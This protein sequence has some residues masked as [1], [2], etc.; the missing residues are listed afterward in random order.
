MFGRVLHYITRK[1]AKSLIMLLILV[2]V[3]IMF[4]T[5]I[6]V[7]KSAKISLDNASEKAGS[8]FIIRN[9][10]QF[11]IG[12]TGGGNVPEKVIDDIASLDTVIKSSRRMISSA[13]MLNATLLEKPELYGADGF[14]LPEGMQN[15]LYIYGTD[16]SAADR[17]FAVETLRISE[18]RHINNESTNAVL[19]HEGF[20]THNGFK[21]GDT[22]TFSPYQGNNNIS[23]DALIVG[24]FGGESATKVSSA[25][26][27][28]ENIIYTDLQTAR[29]IDE[30]SEENSVYD[31][32]SF[33]TKNND[34][35]QKAMA[36]AIG[37]GVDLKMYELI[38][39]DSQFGTLMESATVLAELVDNLVV[40]S[41]IIG[42]LLVSFVLFIWIRG[43]L[44]ETGILLSIGKSKLSVISGYALELIIIAVAA[45]FISYFCGRLVA[46]NIGD[47]FSA[48][49]AES[50]MENVSGNV[51]M[52]GSDADSSALIKTATLDVSVQG[53]DILI[54]FALM[55]AVILVAVAVSSVNIIRLKPRELLS[56]MS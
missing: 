27:L 52:L 21:L 25:Y 45:L 42:A 23:V 13:S 12:A 34:D 56:K 26:D 28:N 31:H 6:S 38:A 8:S 30:V 32:A 46:Q 1:W 35:M 24:I 41:F 49:A 22:I 5:G 15:S 36:D 44:K 37:T 17:L 2:G 33:Y 3:G 50:A 55:I 29:T 16:N 51:G 9:N 19:I 7:Q 20:A 47:I 14:I 40:W 48:Q 4:F 53:A 39:G 43:R 18:G 54:V 11:N 10:L